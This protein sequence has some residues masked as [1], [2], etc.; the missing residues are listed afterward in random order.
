ML[1]I[2]VRVSN[3]IK[4]FGTSNPYFITNGLNIAIKIHDL[5]LDVR[6]YFARALRRKYIVINGNMPELNQE[7]TLC[8]ELGHARLHYGYGYYF[9]ANTVYYVPAKRE[10]EANEFALHLLSHLTLDINPD[11]IKTMLKDTHPN[12]RMV[13]KMLCELMIK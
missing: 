11:E 7:I 9:N 12:P 8:H 10:E 5:P 13:H 3:L 1:N 4:K 2:K 6:G